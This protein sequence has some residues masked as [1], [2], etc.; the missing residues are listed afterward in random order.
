L[1]N[2]YW[3]PSYSSFFVYENDPDRLLPGETEPTGLIKNFLSR[4]PPSPAGAQCKDFRLVRMS[5]TDEL[6][7][8]QPFRRHQTKSKVY[9]ELEGWL[10]ELFR[11]SR[12]RF[13][14]A[15]IL[16]KNALPLFNENGV[17][18]NPEVMS[19]L[20]HSSYGWPPEGVDGLPADRLLLRSVT[21]CDGFDLYYVEY[22]G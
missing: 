2:S 10:A 11:P 22:V 9:M 13:W 4:N 18:L 5:E 17:G 14:I 19:G 8:E 3:Y 6:E 16:P 7:L 21:N 1:I 20:M 12:A 15:A